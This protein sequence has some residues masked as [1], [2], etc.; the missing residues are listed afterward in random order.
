MKKSVDY[1]PFIPTLEYPRV[2]A[3][4]GRTALEHGAAG[5]AN[6]LP[7]GLLFDPWEALYKPPPA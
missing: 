3:M 6:P 7:R 1:H 4:H 2:K 5:Y